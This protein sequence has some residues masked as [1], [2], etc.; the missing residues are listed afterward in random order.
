MTMMLSTAPIEKRAHL[1][2]IL[3]IDGAGKTTQAS[4]IAEWLKSAGYS[5]T[6]HPNEDIL[7]AMTILDEIARE[8]GYDDRRVLLGADVARLVL[9]MLKWN[10][11]IKAR[12]ALGKEGHFVIMDRY[13]YCYI[14]TA[15]HW[16]SGND[17][18]I[19]R[20]FDIFPEPD[21]SLLIDVPPAEAQ[22]RIAARG[23]ERVELHYLEKLAS[24]YKELPQ[25][26]SFTVV[27]GDRPR[28]DVREEIR[29][30][31]RRKFPF[32]QSMP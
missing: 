5:V 13:S 26:A 14:A 24:A 20:L 6:L 11:M 29:G 25:A 2:V 32:L 28:D 30:Y 3:G 12:Q 10:M 1:V 9:I 18:L 19:Q 22:Q 4:Y 16:H 23:V 27:D 15:R 31:M 17:W 8:A 7:P 21:L